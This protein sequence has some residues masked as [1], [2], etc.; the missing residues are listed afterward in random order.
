M[1][2]SEFRRNLRAL[3]KVIMKQSNMIEDNKK[4]RAQVATRIQKCEGRVQELLKKVT[5]LKIPSQSRDGDQQ[6]YNSAVS[7]SVTEEG[8]E[9]EDDNYKAAH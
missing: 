2:E 4:L 1:E 3:K 6:T 7:G 8:S 9:E 5:Q